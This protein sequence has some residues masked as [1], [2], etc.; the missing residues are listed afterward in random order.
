VRTQIQ[1]IIRKQAD[2]IPKDAI[3]PAEEVTMHLPMKI[4]KPS[5]HL[6]AFRE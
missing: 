3:H 1:D 4:G 5:S 2:R 6:R